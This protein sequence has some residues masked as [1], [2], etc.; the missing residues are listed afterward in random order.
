MLV[1][2]GALFVRLPGEGFLMKASGRGRRK[3]A[4]RDA[5]GS[6][7]RVA[8]FRTMANNHRSCRR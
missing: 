6:Y 2:A 3:A 5:L 4:C 1:V 7:L 8:A